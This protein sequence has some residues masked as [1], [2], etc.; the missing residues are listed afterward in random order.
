MDLLQ[1]LLGPEL[2]SYLRPIIHAHAQHAIHPS[3]SSSLCRSRSSG[4]SSSSG[5][6]RGSSLAALQR[7]QR[8]R[9]VPRNRRKL[10]VW[11]RRFQELPHL[12][13]DLSQ[14]LGVHRRC[15]PDH[16]LHP[17]DHLILFELQLDLV[18][19]H[20]LCCL[21]FPHLLCEL[22]LLFQ[23]MLRTP[24]SVVARLQLI[25]PR[26][27]ARHRRHFHC[28]CRRLLNRLL[29]RDRNGHRRRQRAIF[30]LCHDEINSVLNVAVPCLDERVSGFLFRKT[31]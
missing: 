4:G 20:L 26:F 7:R 9:E 13:H 14:G 18:G 27:P 2:F 15:L 10:V 24:V 23:R 16:R 29:D 17:S 22:L 6:L 3:C 30:P 19:S 1:G 11:A 28:W 25:C 8:R 12:G 21:L 5:G 31:H